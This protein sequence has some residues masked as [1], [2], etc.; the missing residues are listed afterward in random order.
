MPTDFEQ[1]LGDRLLYLDQNREEWTDDFCPLLRED[2][3]LNN[4]DQSRFKNLSSWFL[5][6]LLSWKA[7]YFVSDNA[8]NSL[9]SLT[10]RFLNVLG[11]LVPPLRSLASNFPSTV[12]GAT[13]F[14]HVGYNDFER[15][16]VCPQCCKLYR[17]WAETVPPTI[18][19][20]SNIVKRRS[21]S[22]Q[23][24]Q[25]T[26]LKSG[27]TTYTPI[28]TYC[29][30]PLQKSIQQ[31]LQRP[32]I[33][34]KCEEWRSREVPA[35]YM[36]DVFEGKR[37]DE[38]V[39]QHEHFLEESGNLALMLNCDWFQ[40]FKRRNNVSIGVLYAVVM[41]LPRELRFKRENV[42]LVSVIPAFNPEPSLEPFLN[43][44]VADLQLLWN[45]E[46]V[47]MPTRLKPE[48]T[49][50]RAALLCC[51]SDIPASRKLGGFLSHS[52]AMGCNKCK[53]K[54]KGQVGQKKDYGGF[55]F[56]EWE[57]RTHDDHMTNL[58][59]ILAAPN[60]TT[61]ASLESQ[62]GIRYS[63]LVE[64]PYFDAIKSHAIDPMHCLYLGIAR[65]ILKGWVERGLVDLK[66]VD[67]RLAFLHTSA[68]GPPLPLASSSNLSSWTARELK[69]WTQA[70]MFCLHNLLEER[71]ILLW[72]K[73]VLACERLGKPYIS[74]QDINIAHNLLVSFGS[75]V[76]GVYEK[77]LT[78]PNMHMACHLKDSCELFGPIYG[79]WLFSFERYNG[80][81]GN[82]P[83][84][85]HRIEV[86]LMQKFLQQ[87]EHLSCMQTLD[88]HFHEDF[89]D[90]VLTDE[91]SE[92]I[93]F[94]RLKM[95]HAFAVGDPVCHLTWA[96]IS[97]V[98]LPKSFQMDTFGG[99][100]KRLLA[101]CYEA[102]YNE[103]FD[104][105]SNSFLEYH[106][107]HVSG[108]DFSTMLAGGNSKGTLAFA[109]QVFS[110]QQ[111]TRPVE[112]MNVFTHYVTKNA[113]VVKHVFATVRWLTKP[114]D[115]LLRHKE[116]SV[117]KP[118]TVWHSSVFEPHSF[119]TFL[120]IQ[121]LKAHAIFTTK[122]VNGESFI[123]V[124][125]LPSKVFY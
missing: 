44:L 81:M 98:V 106:T 40:P 62:F 66:A 95:H 76:D 57:E 120:P 69:L 93:S 110:G 39:Q 20:C 4:L 37:W 13:A 74:A 23:L 88:N 70:S 51:S 80:I 67:A 19:V 119:Q 105:L 30:R 79:F 125:P 123:L 73:F 112:V 46:G 14:L 64:L 90:F 109:V 17:N 55:R 22:T 61:K 85:N 124:T 52:A 99:N 15:I 11:R 8:T 31:L 7:R 24:F 68:G 111:E 29:Y 87:T 16:V 10:K 33:E 6:S 25:T 3:E 75:A 59:K 49:K 108:V 2:F 45:A 89:R 12:K 92:K 48:G 42:L 104:E 38:F 86:Q 60:K 115:R 5:L 28:K 96:D 97:D 58:R 102:M 41:N 63:P 32:Q 116:L 77:Q 113:T 71:H 94:T 50:V 117:K 84:N 83:V 122:E 114:T 82:V 9:L 1:T 34:E 65:G 121:C 35:G 78:T 27:E 72:Q 18:L 54:F 100:D 43:P 101:L 47:V 118:F 36:G 107:C 103:N 53:T 21:C 26:R 56:A 91:T